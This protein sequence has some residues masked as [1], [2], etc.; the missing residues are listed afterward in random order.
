MGI[1]LAQAE[2]PEVKSGEQV[3]AILVHPMKEDA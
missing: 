2:A 1:R 3:N